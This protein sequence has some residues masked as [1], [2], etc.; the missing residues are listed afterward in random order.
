MAHAAASADAHDMRPDDTVM[1]GMK[2]MAIQL[3]TAHFSELRPYRDPLR[4]AAIAPEDGPDSALEPRQSS[5]GP[6]IT[7]STALR[8]PT[9]CS[10][11]VAVHVAC[12]V[13][14]QATAHGC[15]ECPG[16]AVRA[17]LNLTSNPGPKPDPTPRPPS[18]TK[19]KPTQMQASGTHACAAL[20]HPVTLN[21]VQFSFLT[22]ADRH[23]AD[24]RQLGVYLAEAPYEQSGLDGR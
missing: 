10:T 7:S 24:R 5:G 17:S 6:R 16:P 14:M 11:S 4:V 20:A 12:H 15:S 2:V 3:Q 1:K 18:R 19:C 13:S 23:A 22:S 9:A 8:E 21:P